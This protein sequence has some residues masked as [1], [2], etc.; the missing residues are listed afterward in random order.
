M[1]MWFYTED[2]AFTWIQSLGPMFG[3]ENENVKI[4]NGDKITTRKLEYRPQQYRPEGAANVEADR[5]WK[6]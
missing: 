2:A 5:V 6:Q 1:V 3:N 4:I